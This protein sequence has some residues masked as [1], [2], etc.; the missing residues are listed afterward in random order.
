MLEAAQL[1]WETVPKSIQFDDVYYTTNLAAEV[2][3]VFLHPNHLPERFSQADSF[4]LAETGFGTGLNFLSSVAAWLTH[5]PVGAL[6]HYYSVEKHPIAVTDLQRIYHEHPLA[7]LALELLTLYPPMRTGWHRLNL[8][9]G[10]VVLNLY[11]GDALLGYQQLLLA[12][13][14]PCVQAWFLDG[15]APSKNSSI[16]SLPLMQTLY[17]LSCSGCSLATFTASGMVRRHL[18]TAGF[19]VEKI[20]GY[21]RKREMLRAFVD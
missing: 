21:G 3:A 19:R 20:P 1:V 2:T 15:F 6:L 17:Q 14:R 18:Q 13:D 10:R 9:S 12:A 11:F 5:A 7:Q 16:W 4:V 8:C